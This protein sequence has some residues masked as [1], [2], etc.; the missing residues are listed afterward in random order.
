MLDAVRRVTRPGPGR[1]DLAWWWMPAR[2]SGDQLIDA[3]R[4]HL[5]AVHVETE[6]ESVPRLG[7]GMVARVED[8]AAMLTSADGLDDWL[9]AIA[10]A[11]A[12]SEQVRLLREAEIAVEDA[13]PGVFG[14]MAGKVR[15]AATAAAPILK[16]TGATAAVEAWEVG[17]EAAAMAREAGAGIR[18]LGGKVLTVLADRLTPEPPPPPLEPGQFIDPETGCRYTLVPVPPS[19]APGIGRVEE[20]E[21]ERAELGRIVSPVPEKAAAPAV[22]PQRKMPSPAPTTPS[23]P[24]PVPHRTGRPRPGGRGGGG[25]GE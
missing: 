6:S 5:A 2:V 9:Q 3:L 14:R 24:V 25:I 15:A 21:L 12:A 23:P 13:G 8:L 1:P 16:R 7:Q 4:R 10:R 20:A 17:V 19:G 22:V 11:T 18:V